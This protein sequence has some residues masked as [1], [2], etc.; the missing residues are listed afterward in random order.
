MKKQDGARGAV[1]TSWGGEF[2]R[3]ATQASDGSG[4]KRQ[5]LWRMAVIQ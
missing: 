4:G 3:R 2:P 5:R 1:A